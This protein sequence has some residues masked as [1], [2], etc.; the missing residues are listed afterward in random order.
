MKKKVSL[1]YYCQKRKYF[2]EEEK[3]TKSN[4]CKNAA[5]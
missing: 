2:K 1:L 5:Y 4:E 3:N